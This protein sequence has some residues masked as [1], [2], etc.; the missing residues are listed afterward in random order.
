ME[1][2]GVHWVGHT[3]LLVA[4]MWTVRKKETDRQHKIPSERQDERSW[5]QTEKEAELL[6][7]SHSSVSGRAG[8]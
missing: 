6:A 5:P 1:E 3:V 4:V 2:P 8:I 7:K